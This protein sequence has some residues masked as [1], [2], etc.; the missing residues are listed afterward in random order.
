MKRFIAFIL[1]LITAFTL[2]AG[3]A[4]KG[5]GLDYDFTETEETRSY[6]IFSVQHGANSVIFFLVKFSKLEISVIFSAS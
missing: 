1:G 5:G 2:F 6:K 3:C 4:P